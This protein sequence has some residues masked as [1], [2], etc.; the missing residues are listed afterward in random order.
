MGTLIGAAGEAAVWCVSCRCLVTERGTSALLTIACTF[1]LPFPP[2]LVFFLGVSDGASLKALGG[3]DLV[4]VYLVKVGDMSLCLTALILCMARVE[5]H[6][7]H[8]YS[9]I[10]ASLTP[11]KVV[12]ARVWFAWIYI[13]ATVAH[14]FRI[15]L[16]SISPP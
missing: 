6:I 13:W 11:M 5:G 2:L 4:E 1:S 12:V 14:S 3:A 9:A 16:R 15:V 8:L 7:V 10:M